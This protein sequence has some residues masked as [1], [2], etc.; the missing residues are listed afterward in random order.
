MG[1]FEDEGIPKIF[2][3]KTEVSKISDHQPCRKGETVYFRDFIENLK[4][5]ES[6]VIDAEIIDQKVN[7]PIKIEDE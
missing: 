3:D 7:I 6:N 1:G 5:D 4:T 2:D